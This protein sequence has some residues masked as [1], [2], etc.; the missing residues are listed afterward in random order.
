MP[1]P[2]ISAL[3]QL[4][5]LDQTLVEDVRCGFLSDANANAGLYSPS[6]IGT[7]RNNSWQVERFL[8]ESKLNSETALRSLQRAMQWR[9]EQSVHSLTVADFPAEYYQSGYIMRY[10]RDIAGATV[11][12]FRANIHRKTTEWNE[13]L[14]RF[15]IY[16]IEQIDL[17]NDGK[18]T[19]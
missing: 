19:A 10:G 7:I 9:K 8:L 5:K 4:S 11:L 17:H 12:T 1:A 15:F 13:Q 6:D 14:K 2:P 16:Q 18:G 3:E